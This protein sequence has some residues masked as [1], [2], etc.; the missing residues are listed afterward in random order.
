[1]AGKERLTIVRQKIQSEKKITVSDLSQM[2]KVT[3]ETIRRDLDKLESEGAIT[4]VHGGAIWNE[5]VQKEGIHFYRRQSKHL[6]EKQEIARKT[7]ELLKG[8]CTIIADSSTTVV[9]ALKLLPDSADITVVTNSTEVFREFQESAINFVSS[10]GEFNKKSLSLQGQLAK[11]NIEQYNV[12]LALISCKGLSIEK[13]VF[14]SNEREAVIKKA[15]IRQ[16]DEV[17]LLADSS[18]FD[19][20][21]FVNLMDLKR[22][23]YIITDKRPEDVWIE[24]CEE[25]GIGLIY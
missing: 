10:G 11:S 4:R 25:N 24:Y 14:D 2:C 12:S 3:E 8:K 13:G 21:A 20:T 22:L 6:K 9:E 23:D 17:V 15:M 1:M 18:K 19:Q 7:V 5:G 16:A